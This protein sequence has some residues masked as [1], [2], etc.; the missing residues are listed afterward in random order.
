MLKQQAP[1]IY[2]DSLADNMSYIMVKFPKLFEEIQQE[3][4]YVYKNFGVKNYD[5]NFSLGEQVK[6]LQN[7]I[8]VFKKEF[9]ILKSIKEYDDYEKYLQDNIEKFSNKQSTTGKSKY[10]NLSINF[11]IE[12]L[13]RKVNDEK[14][15]NNLLNS[16][17]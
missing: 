17:K 3:I 5:Y 10:E 1:S 16:M 8:K 4:N 14:E 2:T 12:S 13:E 15:L 9:K 7:T 6:I 11:I